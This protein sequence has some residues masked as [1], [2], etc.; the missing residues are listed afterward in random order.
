MIFG[1]ICIGSQ[2][3]IIHS[4]LSS[5]RSTTPALCKSLGMS[6]SKSATQRLRAIQFEVHASNVSPLRHYQLSKT[7]KLDILG[8]NLTNLKTHIH[9]H[10]TLDQKIYR[11]RK[12]AV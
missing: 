5:T 3:L 6:T 4:P 9:Q 11:T 1:S 12:R 10:I 2:S 7:P 8:H